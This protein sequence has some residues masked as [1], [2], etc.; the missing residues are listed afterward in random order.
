MPDAR[1]EPDKISGSPRLGTPGHVRVA[2]A[3][4]SD[5]LEKKNFYLEEQVRD[6]KYQVSSKADELA[7]LQE[8]SNTRYADYESKL[9]K[10][11]G[12]FAQATKNIDGYRATIAE[13]DIQI[14][15]L[16]EEISQVQQREEKMKEESQSQARDLERLASEL[17]SLKVSQVSRNSNLVTRIQIYRKCTLTL[18]PNSRETPKK[19][20]GGQSAAALQPTGKGKGR[21]CAVQETRGPALGEDGCPG[22]CSR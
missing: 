9:K 20:L 16:Q 19:P 11:R 3:G 4:Q 8:N 22:K 15:N 1:D 12:I 5:N 10:M 14:Q 13:K 17:N 21:A 2:S 6:L 7:K 18:S